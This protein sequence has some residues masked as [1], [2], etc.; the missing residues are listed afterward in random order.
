MRPPFA[1]KGHRTEQLGRQ[2]ETRYTGT[3][4]WM[5]SLKVCPGRAGCLSFSIAFVQIQLSLGSPG[6]L[7]MRN[8]RNDIFGYRVRHAFHETSAYCQSSARMEKNKL[9]P[10]RSRVLVDGFVG[11]DSINVP[12][13]ATGVLEDRVNDVHVHVPML[14]G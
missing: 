11:S 4:T 6:S 5:V 13:D 3:L 8:G 2:A 10:T 14:P 12:K 9:I 1:T 7:A